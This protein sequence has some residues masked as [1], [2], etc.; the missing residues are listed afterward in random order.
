MEM[1]ESTLIE[2]YSQKEPDELLA[3]HQSGNLTDAAYLA[4]ESVMANLN[5]DIP[6]R[7]ERYSNIQ[8]E[9]S[10]KQFWKGSKSPKAAF[11][12]VSI[13]GSLL[14][15]FLAFAVANPAQAP[16]SRLA[17]YSAITNP[18]F[19]FAVIVLWR[20]VKGKSKWLLKFIGLFV[21][22]ILFTLPFY[23]YGF[24]MLR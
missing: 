12:V 9:D 8:T 4:I 10:L 20:C 6:D 13:A 11:W 23:L 5:I 17:I 22:T 18:Y 19:I 21:A 14:V 3:L 7:P 1:S 16:Y 15:M 24:I 2:Q